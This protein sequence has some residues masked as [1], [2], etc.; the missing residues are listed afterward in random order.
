[1]WCLEVYKLSMRLHFLVTYSSGI[2]ADEI[3]S[4]VEKIEDWL[5]EPLVITCDVV[6]TA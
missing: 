6:T 4:V 5:G 1:M 3:E 2:L